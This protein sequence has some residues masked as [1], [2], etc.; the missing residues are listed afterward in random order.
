VEDGAAAARERDA[1]DVSFGR[2]RQFVVIATGGGED[3]ALMAFAVPT[4][5]AARP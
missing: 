4:V 1:D 5:V 2:R 3:A